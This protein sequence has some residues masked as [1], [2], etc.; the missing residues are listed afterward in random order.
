MW[1]DPIVEE[2]RRIREEHAA[3][4]GYDLKAIYDDLKESEKKSG[5][6]VVSFPPK[7]LKEKR[8][9]AASRE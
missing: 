3:Q 6:V 7:R 1:E 8:E 4:F 9:K 5:R 2:V